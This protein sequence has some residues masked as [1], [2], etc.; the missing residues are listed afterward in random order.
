LVSKDLGAVDVIIINT[1]PTHESGKP[2]HYC[3]S[4]KFAVAIDRSD[5]VID[6][7]HNFWLAN[8]TSDKSL[9]RYCNYYFIGWTMERRIL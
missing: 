8:I 2:T 6:L 9:L 1:K 7:F 5:T 3:S 4:D